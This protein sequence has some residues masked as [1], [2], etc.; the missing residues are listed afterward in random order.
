LDETITSGD[1]RLS[2]HLALPTGAGPAPALALCHGFPTGPR[3]A[4]SSAATFPELAERVARDAGWVA[5][6]FNCRGTGSSGGD[7]SIS[8]WLAD[9]RAAVDLLE[10][11]PEVRGVWLAGVAE[12]GTLAICE[13]AADRRVRGVATL[14]APWSLRDW[15]RDPVRLVDYAQRVGM[16]RTPGFPPVP[17][18][19]AREVAAVDATDA[20]KQFG[21]R[22]LFVLHGTDDTVVPVDDA[23]ILVEAAGKNAELRLVQSAGHELRHDPRAVA[24]LLGWLDRQLL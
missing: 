17:G 1:V 12:G 13:A 23:R 2:A 11:R 10:H 20:V 6:S 3:G 7:F 19:W 5:L 9:L 8:G 18:A 24:A 22:P 14:A 15:A 21:S 16:V 4:A